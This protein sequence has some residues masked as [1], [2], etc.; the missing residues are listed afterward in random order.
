VEFVF[1]VPRRELFPDSYPHGFTPFGAG[2]IERAA[3]ERTAAT[4]GFFVERA[5]A[6]R[7]P[8]WKQIIPYTIAGTSSPRTRLSRTA[9]ARRTPCPRGRRASCEKN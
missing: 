4:H 5:R 1:V 8:D 6:E 2:G 3:F 9:D 7:E